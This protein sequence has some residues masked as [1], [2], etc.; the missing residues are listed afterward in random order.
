M[1][2]TTKDTKSSDKDTK[3]SEATPELMESAETASNFVKALA[4]HNRLLLLCLLAEGEKS[5]SDLESILGLRQPTISQQL[6]RLR[7]DD[8]VN[9]RR[10]GKTIYYSLTSNEA[11]RFVELLYELFCAPDAAKTKAKV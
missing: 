3:S 10:D 6:A 4:N 7:A 2:V 11:R 5:V 1:S 8:L 9:G